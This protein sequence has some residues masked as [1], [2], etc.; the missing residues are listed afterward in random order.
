MFLLAYFLMAQYLKYNKAAVE[1]LR[2][3]LKLNINSIFT[4]L[5]KN[6]IIIK[7]FFN[8]RIYK[9]NQT[10]EKIQ[11]NKNFNKI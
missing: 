1:P 7:W 2:S 4:L 6:R 8:Q 11:T 3:T 5:R 9:I 10:K